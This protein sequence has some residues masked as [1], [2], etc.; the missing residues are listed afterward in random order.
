MKILYL[1]ARE[2]GWVCDKDESWVSP[3]VNAFLG[4]SFAD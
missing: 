3:R 1:K 2:G 4:I